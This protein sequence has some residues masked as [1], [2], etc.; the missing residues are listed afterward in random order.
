MKKYDA[1]FPLFFKV[2]LLLTPLALCSVLIMVGGSSFRKFSAAVVVGFV[3]SANASP[4]PYRNASSPAAPRVTLD[5]GLTILGLVNSS[6][7]NVAEFLGIPYAKPPVDD[8]R[9]K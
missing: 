6:T 9:C 4:A 3:S 2:S 1:A 5:N 7:P 8:L